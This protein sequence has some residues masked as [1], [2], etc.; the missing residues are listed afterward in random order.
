MELDVIDSPL[1]YWGTQN[2]LN[3]LRMRQQRESQIHWVLME[4]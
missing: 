2:Q 3:S 4:P 1:A